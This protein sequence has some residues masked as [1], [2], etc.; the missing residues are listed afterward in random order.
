MKLGIAPA[1]FIASMKLN[2]N[3]RYFLLK[4]LLV[5][6]V[7]GSAQ[8]DEKEAR[9]LLSRLILAPTDER[10]AV[11]ESLYDHGD[12]IIKEVIEGW[13]I[14]E[15]SVVEKDGV[16]L[17][18]LKRGEGDYEVVETGRLS[19]GEERSTV[20]PAVFVRSC[21]SWSIFSTLVPMIR[22]RGS[23]RR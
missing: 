5:L 6:M 19:A 3:C 17:A 11:V 16:P 7:S 15:I 9:K 10:V 2:K 22:M 1:F 18:L 20:L 4:L 12:E 23:M 21:V 14:G 8:G 13:R